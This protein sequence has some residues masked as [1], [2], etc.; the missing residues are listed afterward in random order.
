MAKVSKNIKKLRTE[1]KMTQG[2]LADKINV[3]RQTVSSWENDRTQPDIDMLELLAEAFGTGIEEII[4]GE[5]RNV[6][7]E[8][9]KPD[10]RKAMNIV[11]ATLGSLLSATG[12]I[13][14]I[15]SFWDKLPDFFL[16]FLSFLPLLLGG[17][18]AAWAY[19]KKKNS[20]GWSEGS[21]VA[22]VAGLVAT[23]CLVVA[24]FSIDID[25][26]LSIIGLSAMILPIAFIMNS[27]FPLTVYFGIT[28]FYISNEIYFGLNAFTAISGLLMF[29]A[30]LIYVIKQPKDDYRRKYS[31]WLVLVSASVISVFLAEDT[32][33]TAEAPTLLCMLLG[34][35]IALYAADNGERS[36][37]PF[38]FI[39]VPAISVILCALCI[40]PEDFIRGSYYISSDPALSFPGT[41]PFVSAIIIALGIIAGK[42]S[43]SK[44]PA[45]TSFVILASLS[46]AL[47][48]V[49]S[50]TSEFFNRDA[51]K[52]VSIIITLISFVASITVIVAGI[53]K[54]KLLTV[55][56]GLIMLCF[57]V[58]LTIF[59][60]NFD[61]VYSGIAC[62]IMGGILLFLNYRMSKSF[63]A[64]EAEKNA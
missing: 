45:K 56:L 62:I 54:A 3:T 26:Y 41:A 16:A 13:I 43:F 60:G 37:Y 61:I 5:K 15:V 63:K 29:A 7:L 42:K 58:Y 9:P 12:L 49:C 46:A 10:R 25:P 50:V 59:A 17:T 33:K 57:L 40:Y 4:Y 30:G 64:K 27:V 52:A 38:R 19:T 20:I 36:A 53:R 48:T 6:G 39:C 8:A 44:N 32:A 24:M 51:D 1:S 34:I 47:C 14:I 35:L 55:N 31:T 2:E 11:F 22:W 21:S 18:I 28:T 23:F